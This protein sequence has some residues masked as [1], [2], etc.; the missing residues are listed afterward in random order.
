[1]FTYRGNVTQASSPGKTT[2]TGYDATG[3]VIEQDDNN[4]HAVNIVTSGATNNTLPDSLTPNGTASLQTQAAYNSPNYFPT[5][6]AGPGQTLYNPTTNPNG[7]A[8]YT[9]YDSY[10]RVAYTQAASQ[11]TT[12]ANGA[13]TN[14]TYGYSAT[15]GW[16]ITA[17]TANSGGASHYTTTTLDGLGRTTRVQTGYGSTIASTVDTLYQPCA[18]S[19]LGK[20][21][22]QSQPYVP[23]GTEVYTTYTY[24]ALGRTVNVLLADGASH[25]TYVYQGN[26]T[27]VTDPAGNWKQY[28]SDAFGNLVM[29]LEPDPTAHPVVGPPTPSTYPVTSAPSGTLLTTYT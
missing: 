26:F 27:T 18:C 20:M 10:G 3:T 13:Q 6:V 2:N 11:S 24:D 7:T 17:T 28:A 14:Y 29:V 21:Y 1:M 9:S 5:S 25:T 16:T 23:T 4:G 19:P 12:T 8:A 15:S 22:Q